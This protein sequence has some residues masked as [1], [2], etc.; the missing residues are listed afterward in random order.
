M[1]TNP[2][3]I[4]IVDT[5]PEDLTS[6]NVE[7]LVRVFGQIS[8]QPGK[9]K[10]LR[11]AVFLGFPS[12][13]SDPR[14]NWLIPEVRQFIRKLDSE[15]PHFSYFLLADVP[16]GFLRPY[17]YCLLDFQPDGNIL[18]TAFMP[19]IRRLEKDIH[20]FCDK[21]ADYPDPIIERIM[22]NLPAQILHNSPPLRRSA[23][24][25]LLPV[26]EAIVISIDTPNQLKKPVIQEAEALLGITLATCKSDEV[27]MT[28][29][30]EEIDRKD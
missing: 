21:I 7:H 16:L 22:I 17:M 5:L 15:M 11:G 24:R 14:P 3:P 10:E 29:V 6:C 1:D 30:R 9:A 27:F 8:Q 19:L 13:E 28:K 2:I 26:L 20:V 4:R 23:L 18:P 25:S 12:V